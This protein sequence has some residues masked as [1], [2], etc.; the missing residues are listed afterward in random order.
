MMVG[1]WVVGVITCEWH[2]PHKEHRQLRRNPRFG[3]VNR[4]T[5]DTVH[6]ATYTLHPLPLPLIFFSKILCLVTTSPANMRWL[7][8]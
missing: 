5:P 6:R 7:N 4:K 1:E 3:E 2:L 8:R